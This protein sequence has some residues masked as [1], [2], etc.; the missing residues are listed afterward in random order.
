MTWD[1]EIPLLGQVM[2]SVRVN[3][4]QGAP[5]RQA[6]VVRKVEPGIVLGVVALTTGEA[7]EG[8]AKWYRT[9][10]DSYLWS[11]ACGPLE[12]LGIQAQGRESASLTPVPAV[13]D[14]FH[15]DGVTSFAAAKL[16]G[17]MGVIHK[18]ST[19]VTGRDDAY[20]ARRAAARQ[21]GLLWGAYHWGT[22]A[23]V[24]QQVQNFLTSADP[25]GLTLVAL[26]F[27]QTPGDQ[28]TLDQLRA[29]SN[30]IVAKL[31]R[32][33]VIYG[34]GRLKAELGAVTDAFFAAHRLWLADYAEEPTLPASWGSFFLWQYTDGKSGPGRKTVPGILGD[35]RGRL[36]CNHFAG[37]PADLLNG[38]AE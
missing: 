37:S 2:I 1:S 13:V 7:V 29:F 10:G 35:R 28:M 36:D 30:Q 14:L 20:Q 17:L 34:G 11:G 3:L 31:G 9:A 21:A 8:N 5:N 18:A 6:P 32:R 15:G 27:E 22:A 19:G 23:P 33:P 25:D 16:S 38:W 12:T 26:D 4:R 24:D